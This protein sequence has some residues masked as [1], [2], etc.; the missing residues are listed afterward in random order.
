MLPNSLRFRRPADKVL[1][2]AWLNLAV[3][4][5]LC[6]VAADR[7]SAIVIGSLWA[8]AVGIVAVVVA[9]RLDKRASRVEP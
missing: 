3:T 1:L 7:V 8:A 6:F 5:L 4:A 2:I 9:R